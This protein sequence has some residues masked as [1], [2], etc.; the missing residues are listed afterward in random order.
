MPLSSRPYIVTSVPAVHWASLTVVLKPATLESCGVKGARLCGCAVRATK[1]QRGHFRIEQPSKTREQP[2]FRTSRKKRSGPRCAPRGFGFAFQIFR[3]QT[4]ARWTTKEMG[5][6][7]YAAGCRG[8]AA[9]GGRVGGAAVAP[10]CLAVR[11]HCA[12]SCASLA[13]DAVMARRC[14][15]EKSPSCRVVGGRTPRRLAWPAPNDGGGGRSAA[16]HHCM[17]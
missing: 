2:P 4:V 17:L 3:C 14:A 7:R 1:Q 10:P 5:R 9:R 6:W 11:E 15:C 8:V 13:F 12:R 16:P